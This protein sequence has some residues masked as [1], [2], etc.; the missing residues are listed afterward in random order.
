[1][2]KYKI[3]KTTDGFG[4]TKYQVFSTKW[5]GLALLKPVKLYRGKHGAGIYSADNY[6]PTISPAYYYEKS[7]EI[8]KDIQTVLDTLEYYERKELYEL[9]GL[10]SYTSVVTPQE[11]KTE[12]LIDPND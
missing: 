4:V 1:M 10:T 7:S 6:D 5:F 2:G 3:V 12:Q 11:L 9:R 8:C